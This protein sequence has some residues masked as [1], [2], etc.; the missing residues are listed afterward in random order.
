MQIAKIYGL[1][2]FLVTAAVVTGYLT[3]SFGFATTL[4]LGFI[5]SILAGTGLLV[6]YPALMSEDVKFVFHDF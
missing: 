1:V 5:A 4:I 2:L 6:V 3:D